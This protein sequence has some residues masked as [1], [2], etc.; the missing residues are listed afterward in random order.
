MTIGFSE[1]PSGATPYESLE[2]LIRVHG[3]FDGGVSQTLGDLLGMK[4]QVAVGPRI[5][6]P[7]PDLSLCFATPS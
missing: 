2:I 7:S 3:E 6:G 5:A 1:N 4:P